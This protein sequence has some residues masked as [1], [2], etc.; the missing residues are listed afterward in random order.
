MV[1][2]RCAGQ[3]EG[4]ALVFAHTAK[5]A[6]KIGWGGIGNDLTG[7]EYIDLA[8]TIIKDSPWIFGEADAEKFDRSE[9][10]VIDSPRS[11]SSCE[12]WGL[13]IFADGLC[14]NCRDNLF[15]K[16]GG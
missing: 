7:G 8:V 10:H 1:Y 14:S 5:E 16:Y 4:A 3:S 12:M 2:S 9:P 11:C 13:E 15:D 6:K